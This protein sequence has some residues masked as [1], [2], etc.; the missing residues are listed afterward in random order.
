MEDGRPKLKNRISSFRGGDLRDDDLKSSSLWKSEV[1]ASADRGVESPNHE[2]NPFL[3][4]MGNPQRK[5]KIIFNRFWPIFN[6]SVD[7]GPE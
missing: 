6:L 2:Q 3:R 7:K 4:Q 5:R 1:S